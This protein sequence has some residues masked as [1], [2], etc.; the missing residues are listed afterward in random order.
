MGTSS[1]KLVKKSESAAIIRDDDSKQEEAENDRNNEVGGPTR[2]FGNFGKAQVKAL[3]REMMP[4]QT[5]V[6]VGLFMNYV[7]CLL[8]QGLPKV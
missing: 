3:K 5:F 8:I 7:D 4:K 2:I 6:Q 1:G